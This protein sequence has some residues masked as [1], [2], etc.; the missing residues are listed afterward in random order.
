MRRL[1]VDRDGEW[2][3]C[4]NA[5]AVKRKVF[6]ILWVIFFIQNSRLY[7]CLTTVTKFYCINSNR[8][9]ISKHTSTL[10]IT[11][12]LKG[13]GQDQRRFIFAGPIICNI[14]RLYNDRVRWWRFLAIFL[15][16]ISSWV[17]YNGRRIVKNRSC[18]THLCF[19]SSHDHCIGKPLTQI[20]FFLNVF[21]F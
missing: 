1:M 10:Y 4:N 18:L 15:S 12:P 19:I 11:G 6:I 2:S 16:F 13:P 14:F 9:H 20:C 3:H 21:A 17:T 5:K 8:K 7:A